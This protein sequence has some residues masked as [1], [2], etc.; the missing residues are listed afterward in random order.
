MGCGT[1]YWVRV[2]VRVLVGL[3][4]YQ[5]QCNWAWLAVPAQCNLGCGPSRRVSTAGLGAYVGRFA[6]NLSSA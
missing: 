1:G 4:V 5:T 2:Q 3:A 6:W